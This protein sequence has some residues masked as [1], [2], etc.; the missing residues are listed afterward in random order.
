MEKFKEFLET[1]KKLFSVLAQRMK[2]TE[3]HVTRIFD[4]IHRIVVA[5]NTF[6][7]STLLSLS[8][9]HNRLKILESAV[10]KTKKKRTLPS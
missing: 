9:M 3:D 6:E 5:Q 8:D 1:Q 10:G 7:A 2:V 4:L